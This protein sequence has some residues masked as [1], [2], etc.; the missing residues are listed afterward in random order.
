MDKN[1]FDEEKQTTVLVGNLYLS[2][3]SPADKVFCLCVG[4][5]C[6]DSP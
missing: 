4:N 6:N 5:V 2:F 1:G 3:I